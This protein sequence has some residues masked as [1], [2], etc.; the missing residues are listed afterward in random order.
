MITF[1]AVA[2][3]SDAMEA[4]GATAHGLLC[5]CAE[6]IK[7]DRH[8]TWVTV[9]EIDLVI[10]IVSITVIWNCLNAVHGMQYICV[11]SDDV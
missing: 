5:C 2:I 9:T 1:L 7:S 3:V 6:G 11:G 8:M 10:D 4:T